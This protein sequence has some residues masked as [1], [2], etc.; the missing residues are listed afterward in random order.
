M[1]APSRYA[2]Y[3]LR[4]RGAT[5]TGPADEVDRFTS[6]LDVLSARQLGPT[7]SVT[8]YGELTR[9]QRRHA[10]HAGLEIGPVAIQDLFVHLTAPVGAPADIRS[11]R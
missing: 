5:V 4:E 8:T 2:F 6:G 7:K 3:D 1:D 9:E 10:T 11:V